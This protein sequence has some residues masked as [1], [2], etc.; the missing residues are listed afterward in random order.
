MG[1]A[2]ELLV[3]SP[4]DAVLRAA[5]SNALA[6]GHVALL[7][8]DLDEARRALTR[9]TVDLICLDTLLPH[10]E[11]ERFWSWLGADERR[12]QTPLLLLAPASAALAPAALP[13]FFQPQHHELLAKPLRRQDLARAVAQALADTPRRAIEE[14]P[15]LQAGGLTLDLATHRLL[16][17]GGGTA[18]L[19]PTEARLLACLM[20]HP[21]EY[22]APEALLDRVWSYPAGTGGREVVRAHVSNV[23]RKLRL[24]GTDPMLLRNIP[25][26]GYAMVEEEPAPALA[27]S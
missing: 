25:S 12:A 17:S 20:E 21:G 18:A 5:Q 1:S 11:L 15:L 26:L 7:A 9:S 16:A 2:V 13:S 19:T 4:D 22:V 8:G 6:L 14:P 10:D 23:R 3:V 27:R 24:L